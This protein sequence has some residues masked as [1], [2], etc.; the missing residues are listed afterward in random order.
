MVINSSLKDIE[1]VG[2]GMIEDGMM[3]DF[4]NVFC[5]AGKY[6]KIS[7]YIVYPHKLKV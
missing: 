5:N 6:I 7:T 4:D 2:M 3:T 1:A